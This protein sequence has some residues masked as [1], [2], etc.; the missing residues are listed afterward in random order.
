MNER[1]SE[2]SCRLT[3]PKLTIRR[4]TIL[5]EIRGA[6]RETRELPD[7]FALLLPATEEWKAKLQKFVAFEK[8]CCGFLSFEIREQDSGGSLWLYVSGPEGAKEF[9]RTEL[10]LVE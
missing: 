10:M 7:G 6:S 1:P 4:L 3:K 9:V 5:K 2:L 8:Q